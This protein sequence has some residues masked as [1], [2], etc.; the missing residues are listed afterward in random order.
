MSKKTYGIF[1][2]LAVLAILSVIVPAQAANWVLGTSGTTYIL[3]SIDM[4]DNKFGFAVGSQGTILKT[5]NGG[6]SWTAV[7][8][9]PVDLNIYDV[10]IIDQN[11]AWAV[12][13][14]SAPSFAGFIL[15]TIDGGNTWSSQTPVGGSV[16]LNSVFFF[17][18]STGFAVG[19]DGTIWQ[20]I[21]GGTNWVQKNSGTSQFL[22]SVAGGVISGS[23]VTR[24]VWAVGLG[25]T[26]LRS[27]QLTPTSDWTTWAAQSAP[28]TATLFDTTIFA[29]SA[30]HLSLMAVG[31]G[32]TILRT[33]DSGATWSKLT[34]PVSDALTS[35]KL[36]GSQGFIVGYGSVI[37][38][39][40]DSGVSWISISSPT[41]NIFYGVSVQNFGSYLTSVAVGGNGTV[42]R[43]EEIPPSQPS[44]VQKTTPIG[45]NTPT[46]LWGTSSDNPGDGFIG[47][48]IAKY[49]FQMDNLSFVNANLFTTVNIQSAQA[50]GSHTFAVRAVDAAGN[51][52]SL[53]ILTYN[54]DTTA[55]VVGAV[56]P[57]T[58]TVGVA[59]TFSATFSDAVG[60]TNC[61]FYVNDSLQG[62][63]S[64]NGATS[65]SASK[66]HTFSS[67]GSYSVKVGCTD[68]NYDG[69][70][71]PVTV[72][73]S[74]AA[75]ADTTAPDT[76]INS[77][78]SLSTVSTSA[79]F[80][81]SAN[82]SATFECKLDTGI[83]VVCTSPKIYDGLS[84]GSHTF[85]AR[86]IDI[87]LNV[88][89]TPDS[90]T[91]TITGG[92]P[93]DTTAPYV[94]SISPTTAIAT[95]SQSFTV[96]YS[97]S[98]GVTSC[99]LYVDSVD[100]GPMALAG[101]T[102]GS[103]S[104]EYSFLNTT[105]HTLQA[106]C[107][108]AAGNVGLGSLTTVSV[109]AAPA[110]AVDTA[111]PSTPPGLQKISNDADATP[112]FTW[113]ATSD[114][115]G[116]TSY[117]IQIDNGSLIDNGG[118][119][120]YTIPG[121]LANGSHSFKVLAKDAAGNTSPTS[122]FTFTVNAGAAA[123]SCPLTMQKA[124][125]SSASKAVFY[126]TADCT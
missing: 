32:G 73:V 93:A 9:L 97:D 28:T 50:D 74:A 8:N 78:P 39:T 6:N 96:S 38:R 107:S 99:N 83:F 67:A 49:E 22:N 26:I 124:Y 111:S 85:Q 18:T 94:S 123:V 13:R 109:S 17:D 121:N 114:N 53:N 42:A 55:P 120:S 7:G 86:A 48:G 117:W 29:S 101:T 36:A 62:S 66:S 92:A 20:T 63:M 51:A 103:A 61:W 16:G 91:W 72:V 3:R 15:K 98:V 69:W 47:T 57:I 12:G 89:A 126:I 79:T 37:L 88:D 71:I 1:I 118:S 58:A 87:A 31:S 10:D 43:Y 34:P 64:L 122:S 65:G 113:N 27:I 59:K 44:S 23:V 54:I 102:S 5:T 76:T 21:D 24:A 30:T 116:V 82:E 119:T 52:G 11:T 45:D 41:T 77:K 56:A 90:Y 112:I 95:Y 33:T 80:G 25:G 125:K 60:V 100:Q 81:F 2:T 110:V 40:I 19:I 70:S 14:G 75:A 4:L 115:V 106:R 68:G 105:S 84:V 46:M 35:I 108:D 104:R